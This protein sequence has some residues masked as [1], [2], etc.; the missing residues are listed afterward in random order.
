MR[1][2]QSTSAMQGGYTRDSPGL[3][4]HVCGVVTCMLDDHCAVT[5]D[6]HKSAL[7]PNAALEI[8]YTP[9]G[10]ALPL[11]TLRIAQASSRYH[12]C[13]SGWP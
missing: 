9:T 7:G 11:T 8:I 13:A 4:A 2:M 3:R 12:A 1:V 6:V 10:P 5:V